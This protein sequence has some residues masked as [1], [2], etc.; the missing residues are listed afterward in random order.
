MSNLQGKRKSYSLQY[1]KASDR[2]EVAFHGEPPYCRALPMVPSSR[3]PEL[4]CGNWFVLAFAIW[5]GPDI[6][7]ID[8]ALAAV[9][10]FSGSIQLGV[11]PFDQYTEIKSWCPEAR[12][13]YQSPIWLLFQEGQVVAEFHGP[14][15]KDRLIEIIQS[16]FVQLKS[17]KVKVKTAGN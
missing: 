8:T 3:E 12:T 4:N 11:R 1:L 7:S 5:S 17:T 6:M 9:K 15:S 10:R 16:Q 2:F 14:L 13:S